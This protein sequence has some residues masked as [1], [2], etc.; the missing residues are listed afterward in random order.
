MRLSIV[1]PF[2]RNP[3]M[4]RR[5][6]LTWRDEWPA[7]LKRDIEIVLID[8][9]SP[10]P[11]AREVQEF[12][13]QGLAIGVWRVLEDRPWNQHGARNLGAHVARSRWLL[14]T[15]MDHVIPADTLA[16]VLGAI[17]VNGDGAVFTFPRRDA[18]AGEPWRSDHWQTMAH[19]VNDDGEL[20]PH[21]NSFV[22]SNRMYRK[23]GGYDESYT[24]IYGTDRMFRDRLHKG[25]RL[26]V[27][28]YCPLIRVSRKVI[29]D[30]STETLLRKAPNRGAAKKRVA[31]EKFLRGEAKVIKTL[32]FPWER[33]L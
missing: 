17:E 5:Q 3:S 30:A 23:L 22:L 29:P 21:V 10:E 25:A 16:E 1:M 28:L 14:M 6:L 2:Y 7:D 11:A 19:T 15:D 9:G 20:K 24:G 32:T 12:P 31:A 8:D 26:H 18:P 13:V 27:Q 33:I 4:L